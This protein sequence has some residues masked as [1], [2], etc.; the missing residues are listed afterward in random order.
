MLSAL[1]FIFN[2]AASA[3][4]KGNTLTELQGQAQVLAG[5]FSNE[6]ESSTAS[7]LSIA[8]DGS[9]ASL[10][11]AMDNTG[12]FAYNAQNRSISWQK[13]R[14]YWYEASTK[15]LM[16]K[17]VSVV[18]SAQEVVPASIEVFSGN[19]IESHFNDGRTLVRN[20]SSCH[21]TL[22]PDGL[23]RLELDM[24]KK[25]AGSQRPESFQLDATVGFRN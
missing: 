3:W 10:L 22:T 11:S 24:S 5:K 25:R 7:G 13:Y 12:S 15:E 19:P 8:A 2:T 9:G 18:G 16:I 21:F 4:I 1:F 20:V 6:V 14:V 17:N 23:L